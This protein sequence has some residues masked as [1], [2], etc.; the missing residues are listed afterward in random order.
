MY[1][2]WIEIGK[3]TL[4][5]TCWL[6]VELAFRHP[7]VCGLVLLFYFSGALERRDLPP[8][9]KAGDRD[10]ELRNAIQRIALEWPCYAPQRRQTVIRQN[11]A[12]SALTKEI[13]Q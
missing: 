8:G 1:R 4:G 3:V 9:R 12:D 13:L 6:R 10:I 11:Q 7:L 2:D 5:T